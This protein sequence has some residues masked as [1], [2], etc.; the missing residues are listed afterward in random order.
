MHKSHFRDPE[1]LLQFH[2]NIP[3]NKMI[4]IFLFEIPYIRGQFSVLFRR[5]VFK[6]TFMVTF[7][8]KFFGSV[9]TSAI[10]ICISSCI[11]R[12]FVNKA[13]RKT[14]AIHRIVYFDGNS[15]F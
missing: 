5:F 3:I 4:H 7:I 11:N 2:S 14:V 9:F 15:K 13:L 10:L 8:V 6:R 12:C 1:T